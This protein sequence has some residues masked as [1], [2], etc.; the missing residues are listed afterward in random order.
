MDGSNPVQVNDSSTKDKIMN[1]FSPTKTLPLC[2]N[3]SN[4]MML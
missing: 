3:I 4:K 1:I 2:V